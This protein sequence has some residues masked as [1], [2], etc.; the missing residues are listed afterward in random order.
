MRI[1]DDKKYDAILEASMKLFKAY[2]YGHTTMA[3]IAK[4]AGVSPGTLYIH[5]ENK[6]DLILKLY[7]HLRREMSSF[8]LD[9]DFSDK[10]EKIFKA[11]W[12]NY[13]TY[14]LNNH[15]A[16][17][18][19]MQFMNSPYMEKYKAY[20]MCYF[21]QLHEFF[22]HEKAVGTLKDVSDEILFAYSFTPA[23]QLAK[24][25]RCCGEKLDHE[26][27]QVAC[28]IAWQAISK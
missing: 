9:V 17:H 11:L 12:L 18:Y 5:F 4:E 15:E 3:K 19:M 1:K 21:K 13:Y 23:A 26:S 22:D 10:A 25:N 7:I 14:C 20:G 28:H 16:F 27:V 8:V 6:E 2:G 24:R